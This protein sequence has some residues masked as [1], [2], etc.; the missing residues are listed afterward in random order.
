VVPVTPAFAVQYV[1]G[2]CH[3]R[4][5]HGP[6]TS[7][8]TQL[9]RKKQRSP[10][11]RMGTMLEHIQRSARHVDAVRLRTTVHCWPSVGYNSPPHRSTSRVLCANFVKFG[12]RE[13][14]EIM[15]CLLTKHD[16]T[17]YMTKR[18]QN[19]AWL[20]RCR[21]YADHASRSKSTSTSPAQCT[22]PNRFTFGG[23]SRKRE[24]VPSKRAIK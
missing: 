1:R 14:G 2:A 18:K 17:Q 13:I 21:Y 11:S 8:S 22:H 3:A 12:R 4:T 10:T 24:H 7:W 9:S 5:Q 23:V 16:M 15:R 19:F 20:S 6:R